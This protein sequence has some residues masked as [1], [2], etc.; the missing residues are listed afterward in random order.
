MDSSASIF[1]IKDSV[2]L[3]KA[4]TKQICEVLRASTA[5]LVY[6]ASDG[7]VSEPFFTLSG[8]KAA[9]PTFLNESTFLQS[10]PTSKKEAARK[11]LPQFLPTTTQA[12]VPFHSTAQVSNC[13]QVRRHHEKLHQK[14]RSSIGVA[15]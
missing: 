9:S 10:I 5:R 4:G 15:V 14:T 7:P 6:G 8:Q 12:L 1:A 2:L 13:I 3:C 11:M